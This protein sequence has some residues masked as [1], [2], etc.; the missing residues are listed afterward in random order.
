MSEEY[1]I[2]QPDSEAARGPFSVDKLASLAEA[3]QVT[4]ETLYYDEAREAW[5]RV[6]DNEDLRKQL[7]PE[8]KKLALRSKTSEDMNLLNKQD[9]SE[10]VP[11]TVEQFLSAA[12]G[13]TAE[14]R[15]YKKAEARREKAAQLATPLIGLMMLVTAISLILPSWSILSEVIETSDYF[16]LVSKPLL[17]IG[18]ID[19]FLAI[20][21]FLGATEIYPVIRFRAA[22]GLGYFAFTYWAYH[23]TSGSVND[24]NAAYA[25]IAGGFGMFC[26]TLTLNLFMLIAFAATGLAGAAGFAY[27]TFFMD[28]VAK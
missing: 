17:I 15:H 7:F 18:I 16:L 4:N 26:S 12:E 24:L 10:T 11:V 13:D 20:C 6:V 23:E 21:T 14:T 28:V 25:T 2:R 27:F 9:D 19:L 8:K 1:Y 5:V 3:G 22:A